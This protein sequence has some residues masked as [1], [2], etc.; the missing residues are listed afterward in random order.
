MNTN[1]RLAATL[2]AVAGTES[3][4]GTANVTLAVGEARVNVDFGFAG[5]LTIGDRIW[6]DANGDSVQAATNEQGLF[7]IDVTLV[8]AGQDE[9]FG[10]ADDIT[11]NTTTGANGAYSFSNLSDGDYRI[12]ADTDD[13]PIGATQS[14]D[15]DDAPFTPALDDTARITLAGS[16]R[17][18]MDFGYIGNR[19]LGDNFYH[20]MDADGS[21]D[22]SDPGI[23]DVDITAT[24]AGA[25]GTFGT[26]DDL[27]LTT[28][29]NS[30]GD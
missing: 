9:T 3:I 17:T 4:S 8:Y 22:L 13:L 18:D 24:F 15:E 5:D 12:V 16:D 1:L 23:A 7:G 28:T 20:D 29:T 10:T 2:S 27:T 26:A 30:T 14:H 21:Q 11:K 19:L 6:Y 25:D